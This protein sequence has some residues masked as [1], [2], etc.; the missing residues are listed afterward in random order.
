[1][2]IPLNKS[3]ILRQKKMQVEKDEME[4][5]GRE[6]ERESEIAWYRLAWLEM[7]E[8]SFY[9]ELLWLPKDFWI[10]DWNPFAGVFW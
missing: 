3:N 7:K 8:L 2:I 4:E 1:M 5:S 10:L 6:R 9:V